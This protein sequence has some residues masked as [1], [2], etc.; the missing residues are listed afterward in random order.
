MALELMYWLPPRA[1]KQS[2]NTMMAA[3]MRRWWIRRA[4][5]SG[6]FSSKL[7]QAVWDGPEPV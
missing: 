3:P 4:A 5:R 2:G 6:T 7:R 1:V